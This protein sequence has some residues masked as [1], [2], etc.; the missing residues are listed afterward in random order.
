MEQKT[1]WLTTADQE[2][3]FVRNWYEPNQSPRA[4]IQLAH[5]MA[6]HTARYQRFAEFLVE[7]NFAVYGN[8]HRGHG[9][10]GKKQGTL[11][12]LDENNGF[13]KTVDDLW[14]VTKTIKREHPEKP[15]FLLGHS[16][17]SFLSR[18][19]IQLHGDVLNGVI[20][21]GTGSHPGFMN[22]IGKGL[23]IAERN[24]KG[25]KVPSKLLNRLVFASYNRHIDNQVTEFDWLSRDQEQIRSYMED[26]YAGFVPTAAFF[27][28]LFTGF[29]LIDDPEG[30]DS[31]AKQLPMLFFSGSMD[32]VGAQT[33]GVFRAADTYYRHGITDI[34]I[35]IY[36]NGRHEMLNELNKE[37]VFADI[38][39]WI[40]DVLP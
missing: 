15:V 32:P 16:M 38:V 21:S 11:G 35:R 37:E 26:P 25:V 31:I 27:F 34:T 7:Q 33:K 24:R 36:E 22:N 39:D 30:I 3:V 23:A 9:Y 2:E 40:H 12:F 10:T 28:D 5:G 19:Y 14:S 17:G 8:D 13:D 18:R 29:D 6:E 4:I 1:Y 20:L